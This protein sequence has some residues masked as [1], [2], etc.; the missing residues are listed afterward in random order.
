MDVTLPRGL[1]GSGNALSI[2]WWR[3]AYTHIAILIL[4]L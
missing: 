3:G 2:A 4:N 1:A